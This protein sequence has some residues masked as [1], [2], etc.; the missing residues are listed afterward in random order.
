VNAT[1]QLL[2]FARAPHR[3]PESARVAATRLL[4][5]TLAV[6]AAGAMVSSQVEVAASLWGSGEDARLLG[7]GGRFPAPS[8]AYVNGFR[9][10]G[11]E[12][13]AVHEGAVVHALSVVTAAL[14]AVIDRRGG[15]DPDDALIALAIGV[16][17]ASGLGIASTGAM[18]FFRPATAGVIGA[19]LAAAR[20]NGTERFDDVL[21]FAYSQAAGTMQAHAE[22]SIALPLQIAHAARAAVTAVDLADAGLEAPHDVLEGRFGFF[23]LFEEGDLQ[24]YTD[25][26]GRNWLI[27][28][29]STKPFPSG[30]ASH[31]VL[32]LL[33][34]TDTPAQ[35]IEAIVPPLVHRLVARP[36]KADMTPA[37]ARLCLP[38][39]AALMV[40]DRRIDPRAFTPAT[41][42]DQ[43]LAELASK[44]TIRIDDN[45]DPNALS[46]Q[47][48][49]LTLAD[50]SVVENDIPALL[51]APAAPLS[52]EQQERKRQLARELAGDIPDPRILEDPLGYLTEP[53]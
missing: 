52:S 48:V 4:G 24:R 30:R 35:A 3:L 26:I 9:I 34:G 31:G 25:A 27:E 20:V 50:G 49:R 8:A 29:V 42:A 11:L 2:D 21:G 36:M 46:P 18:R 17:I 53:R 15:C 5:D 37:Y 47:R 33:S 23:R 10:H 16:D 39:L 12:W 32:G 41:F 40:R 22:G 44:V 1:A 45:P 43:A 7:R 13:D 6:G 14:A 38:F 28:E 51:G 19:A